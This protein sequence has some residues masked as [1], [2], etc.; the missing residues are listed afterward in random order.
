MLDLTESLDQPHPEARPTFEFQFLIMVFC[1][2]LLQTDYYKR[3][4][5]FF[6]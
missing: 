2:L 3:E 5:H 6:H 1:Y 4:I